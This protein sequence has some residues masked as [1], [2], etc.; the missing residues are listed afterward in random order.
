[1]LTIHG[2]IDYNIVWDVSVSEQELYKH[3]YIGLVWCFSG[4]LEAWSHSFSSHVSLFQ[5]GSVS[6]KQI[7]TCRDEVTWFEWFQ[8]WML[9]VYQTTS[10]SLHGLTKCFPFAVFVS[11]SHVS[12]T[13]ECSCCITCILLKWNN[14]QVAYTTTE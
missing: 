12:L 6:D 10:V 3:L 14:C 1:M 5:I 7:S 4:I 11:P 2:I 13:S 8:L 9:K